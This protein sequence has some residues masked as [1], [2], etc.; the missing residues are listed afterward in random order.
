MVG[1]AG[2]SAGSSTGSSAGSSTGSSLVPQAAKERTITIARS[3]A[4]SF[5]IVTLLTFCV[6]TLLFL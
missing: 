3:I 5:F 4:R 6:S 1:S 2:S